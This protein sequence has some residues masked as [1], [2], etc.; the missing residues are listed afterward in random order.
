MPLLGDKMIEH[1]L[2]GQISDHIIKGRFESY[3]QWQESGDKLLTKV[4]KLIGSYMEKSGPKSS[5]VTDA[6]DKAM[7][8]S[9]EK[10]QEGRFLL[11][12]VL[13][14]AKY[15]CDARD[16]LAEFS[17][18][19]SD[20]SKGLAVLATINGEDHTSWRNNAAIILKAL[21][22]E[23]DD[24][25]NEQ[26]VNDV[27]QTVKNDTPDILGI[28]LPARSINP[29]INAMHSASS[30]PYLEELLGRLSNED[31][32][33]KVTVIVGGD[34]PGVESAEEIGADYCCKSLSQ[35]IEV[36]ST[37]PNTSNPRPPTM[38]Q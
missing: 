21:G 22:F 14:R 27:L 18:D 25:G 16:T 13:V 17:D 30:I 2:V 8:I 23:A 35:T 24:L 38:V 34:I 1:N 37:L 10:Y 36:L 29:E 32:R 12:D 11:P 3:P 5:V 6:L 15:T 9:F 20:L 26:S 19:V 4:S 28:S 7:D 33:K 31:C